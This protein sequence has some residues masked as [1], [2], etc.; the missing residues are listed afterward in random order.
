MKKIVFPLLAAL[1][2]TCIYSQDEELPSKVDNAFKLKYPDAKNVYWYTVEDG[3]GLEFEISTDTYTATYSEN[4][5][6]IETAKVISDSDVPF[7]VVNAVRKKYPHVDIS[8][9][10]KVETAKEEKYY[11]LNCYSEDADYIID[12][13]AEGTILHTNKSV[14]NYDFD[15]A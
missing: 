2:S 14:N 10:E 15:E 8:Y 5:S 7:E 1:I 13:S 9:A 6:W 4:G 11:R 3:Y 12:V